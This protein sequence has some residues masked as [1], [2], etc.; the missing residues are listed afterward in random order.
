[1]VNFENAKIYKIQNQKNGKIYFGATSERLLCNRMSKHRAR[2]DS[3]LNRTIGDIYDCKIELV[4]K[5]EVKN[6]AE[7]RERERY[8]IEG[9]LKC[10]LCDCVNK[11]IPGRTPKE[12]SQYYKQKKK[13]EKLKNNNV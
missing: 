5:V 13:E 7:L 2:K 10:P 4:E 6:I 1:M 3:L 11:N 12:Y 9:A 8:Y